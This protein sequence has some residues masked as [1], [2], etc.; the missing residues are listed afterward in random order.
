MKNIKN[1]FCSLL[2]LTAI[3]NT[4][5][6]WSQL[7]FSDNF[8]GSFVWDNPD[9]LYYVSQEGCDNLSL[10][11]PIWYWYAQNNI[12]SPLVSPSLGVS[13]GGVATLQ[14]NYKV[15]HINAFIDLP[16]TPDWGKINI[17]Y[18]TSTEG[19]WILIESITPENYVPS[20]GV[21]QTRTVTFRPPAESTIYIRYTILANPSEADGVDAYLHLDNIIV[22]QAPPCTTPAPEQILTPQSLC[23]S[24][25]IGDLNT[26]GFFTIQW[27]NTAE[28]GEPLASNTPVSQGTY[29]AAQI[30][31]GE[32]GCESISR[33]AVT[34]N[35]NTVAPPV[36]ASPQ[37]FEGTAP[38]L[39]YSIDADADGSITWYANEEDAQNG[40][41]RLPQDAII[42][43]SGT[44][45]ATQTINGCE[46]EPFAVN[47]QR[48]LGN[49]SFMAGTFSYYPNPVKSLLH[50]SYSGMITNAIVYNVLGQEVAAYTINSNEAQLDVSALQAG[51]YVVKI[52]D[53]D[54][55]QTVKMVKIN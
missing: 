35:I 27:Y 14:Y 45:Y 34:V 40:N 16:A 12:T 41:N 24:A 20:E 9:E 22:T 47:I 10:I 17:E 51:S 29:Y 1:I 11:S 21:C 50:L 42:T 7:N 15:T 6:A 26:A 53:G 48:T 38:V 18:S 31:E 43:S 30:A 55:Y 25:T 33:T 52:M 32:N 3:T 46:S 49:A 39:F 2:A 44:Y 36:I 54:I 4:N 23:T 37:V 8:E 19:P 13:N 5:K 28:G